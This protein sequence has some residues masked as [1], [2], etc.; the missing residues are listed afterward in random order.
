MGRACCLPAGTVNKKAV[1]KR[2][3]AG[4]NEILT[5]KPSS[6]PPVS[7]A[8]IYPHLEVCSAIKHWSA[9]LPQISLPSYLLFTLFVYVTFIYLPHPPLCSLC[10]KTDAILRT[11]IHIA[12]NTTVESSE[13][14][15]GWFAVVWDNWTWSTK[16][17][18]MYP[19]LGRHTQIK[20]TQN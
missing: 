13:E 15:L 20:N 1:L 16:T 7:S 19:S 11:A 8:G 3:G 10:G 18:V 9:F 17:V 12:K 4:P 6:L 14:S 5:C 2:Q